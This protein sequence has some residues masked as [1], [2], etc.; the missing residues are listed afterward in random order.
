MYDFSKSIDLL[1]YV[2]ELRIVASIKRLSE[3]SSMCNFVLDSI[4]HI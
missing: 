3:K 2:E 4:V 1:R